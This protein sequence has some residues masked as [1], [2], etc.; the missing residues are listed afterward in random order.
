MTREWTTASGG[1]RTS[2]R[3]VKFPVA[4]D[5]RR[6]ARYTSLSL[7]CTTCEAGPRRTTPREGPS[8]INFKLAKNLATLWPDNGAYA[9]NTRKINATPNWSVNKGKKSGGGE[10]CETR[11]KGEA[12]RRGPTQTAVI[13]NRAL[14][15]IITLSV[16][17]KAKH[18]PPAHSL[19]TGLSAEMRSAK[20]LITGTRQE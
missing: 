12:W 7:T 20:F 4:S 8:L 18:E 17:N 10:A 5:Q 1:G 15:R 16:V 9:L 13:R 14:T 6:S 2:G 11:G 3:A 19:G